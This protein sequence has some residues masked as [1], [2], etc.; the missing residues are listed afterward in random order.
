MNPLLEKIAELQ[1][2]IK[3][4]EYKANC[5]DDQNCLQQLKYDLKRTQIKYKKSILR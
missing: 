3:E 2:K 5:I 1:K 4:K